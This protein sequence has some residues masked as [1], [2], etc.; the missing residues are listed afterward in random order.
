MCVV[1]IVYI[2]YIVCTCCIPDL[3][4]AYGPI[5]TYHACVEV[6]ADGRLVGVY[7]GIFGEAGE[8]TALAD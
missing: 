2:V 5:D 4:F 6:D 3:Q 8:E 1:C 7:E